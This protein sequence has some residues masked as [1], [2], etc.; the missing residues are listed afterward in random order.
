MTQVVKLKRSATPGK[1]PTT[2]DL[3]LGE[4]AINTYDGKLY[5]EKDSG[6]P[7]VVSVATSTDLVSKQDTLVSGTNIKTI[8]GSSLMGSGDL[9]ISGGSS[10]LTIQNKTSAYTIVVGDLN[11]IINCTANTF[12]V[13]LPAAATV[14]SGFSCWV[15]NTSN[16]SIDTITISPNGTETIDGSPTL[17]ISCGEGLQVISTDTGWHTGSKKA[18][19]GYAEN[20]LDSSIRP[21][22]TGRR[23]IAISCKAVASAPDSLA[24][25]SSSLDQGAQTALSQGAIAIGG[26][27]A[28]GTDSLAASIGNNTSSYGALYPNSVAIGYNAKNQ[29]FSALAI[30]HLANVSGSYSIGIGYGATTT[31][32]NSI[33]ISANF[34]SRASAVGGVAIGTNAVADVIGKYA[35]SGSYFYGDGTAQTGTYVLS[36]VTTDTLN[37]TKLRTNTDP[38]AAGNQIALPYNSAYAFTG[39]VVARRQGSTSIESAAWHIKGLI[40]RYATGGSTVLVNSA[41]ETIAYPSSSWSISLAAD[42]T[43]GCLA[44]TVTN[45]KVTGTSVR[46]VAT[47]QTSE[48]IYN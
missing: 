39:T 16:T 45:P 3:E 11:S 42:T 27:Y 21:L 48:V 30:G 33:A 40:T 32:S 13:S 20:I 28:S 2:A 43:N 7:T 44:I 19:R 1:V 25:G 35:Y 4:I 10:T 31:A 22:A 14:V 9:S 37:I 12:T 17:T 47:I 5:F 15:W 26:S 24:I 36:G 29:G 18:S 38:A 46:W 23:S 8:N 6:T 34:S 41:I